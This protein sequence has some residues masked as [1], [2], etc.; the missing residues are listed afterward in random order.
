[1]PIATDFAAPDADALPLWLVTPE[2]LGE[3]RFARETP[4]R[5]WLAAT[6]FA[7]GE[8]EIVLLPGNGG[9]LAGA[10]IGT[11]GADKRARAR[12]AVARAAG[13]L[14]AGNWKL[15]E[16]LDDDA[17]AE[18]ALGWLL[19]GYRF[20]RYKGAGKAPA[21]RLVPPANVDADRIALIA[22]S[23]ALTRDLIN[24]PAADMGPAELEAAACARWPGVRRGGRGD[25]R[26]RSAGREPADDPCRRPRLAPC[27]AAD[28]PALGRGARP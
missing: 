6:G 28:R 15:A 7:A 22:Q 13:S 14:P 12:F 20:D 16:A 5:D 9:A 27:A 17:A 10:A 18:A 25:D 21:A 24:T 11:G 19:A 4:A 1:M 26:R 3:W 8:G 23:E 2:G